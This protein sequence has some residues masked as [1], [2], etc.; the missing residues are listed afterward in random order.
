MAG[1]CLLLTWVLG[2]FLAA[3]THLIGVTPLFSSLIVVICLYLPA[4]ALTG[5]LAGQISEWTRS[6]ASPRGGRLVRVIGAAGLVAVSLAGARYTAALVAPENGFVREADVVAMAWVRENVPA[7]ALFHVNGMFWTPGLVHGL[8]AGYWI[9]YLA[10][11]Q[12]TIPP[13][14]YSSDGTPEY[15]AA[16]NRRARELLTAATAS[17]LR[18]LFRKYGVTHVYIGS[19]VTEMRPAF[20]QAEPGLFRPVYDSGGVWIFEAVP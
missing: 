12:V 17:E 9:P 1:C 6:A 5:Y 8:D 7:D 11:R 13:E 2:L 10:G 15:A 16:I 3:N 4:G 18:Q 19:R 20:F 14:T